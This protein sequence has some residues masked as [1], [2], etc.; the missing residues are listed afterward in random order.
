MDDAQ[1]VVEGDRRIDVFSRVEMESKESGL[2]PESVIGELIAL[3]VAVSFPRDL[4]DS[5]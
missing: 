1:L 2:F 3:E 4:V 5:F